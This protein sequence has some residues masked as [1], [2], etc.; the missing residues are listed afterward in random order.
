MTRRVRMDRKCNTEGCNKKPANGFD[1]SDGEWY[2]QECS[3]E[4]NSEAEAD[5]K[6][7]YG[8]ALVLIFT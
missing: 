5:P 2:C 4:L 6:S 7:A 3:E 1:R 8:K